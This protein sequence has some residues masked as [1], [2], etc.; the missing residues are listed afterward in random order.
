ME[1]NCNN[2]ETNLYTLELYLNKQ[3]P[4]LNGFGESIATAEVYEFLTTVY[5]LMQPLAVTVEAH[6]EIPQVRSWAIKLAPFLQPLAADTNTGGNFV[7]AAEMQRMKSILDQIFT[8]LK[9][10][11]AERVQMHRQFEGAYRTGNEPAANPAVDGVSRFES[12]KQEAQQKAAVLKF[13]K[14]AGDVMRSE[15][16]PIVS[17]RHGG[18]AGGRFFPRNQRNQRRH[19]AVGRSARVPGTGA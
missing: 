19:N 16:L 1:T 8:R 18:K 6:D 7:P 12:E 3:Y 11:N 5:K 15:A 9:V 13:E 4:F 14:M 17:S 2:V 10:D